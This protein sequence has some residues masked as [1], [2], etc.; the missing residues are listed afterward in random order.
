MFFEV[1][2]ATDRYGAASQHMQNQTVSPAKILV[3]IGLVAIVALI[4]IFGRKAK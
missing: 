1:V 3:I 2:T 4:I